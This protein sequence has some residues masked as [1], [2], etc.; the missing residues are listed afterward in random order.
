[1]FRFGWFRLRVIRGRHQSYRP[2]RL[3]QWLL[4][5]Y[6]RDAV[7]L[8]VVTSPFGVLLHPLHLPVAVLVRESHRQSGLW[9]RPLPNDPLRFVSAVDAESLKWC[10]PRRASYR[11]RTDGYYSS[12]AFLPVVRLSELGV[13]LDSRAVV[14]PYWMFPEP[15]EIDAAALRRFLSRYRQ[16]YVPVRAGSRLYLMDGVD[17]L[18]FTV[19]GTELLFL[20]WQREDLLAGL[21]SALDLLERLHEWR[22]HDPF[23]Y[24]LTASN[25]TDWQ[26][27]LD[28]LQLRYGLLA[29]D[30]NDPVLSAMRRG[31]DV[32][33]RS[34]S[35][36]CQHDRF[37]GWFEVLGVYKSMDGSTGRIRWYTARERVP[38]HGRYSLRKLL[39]VYHLYVSYA[40]ARGLPERELLCALPK[41]RLYVSPLSVDFRPL[42]TSFRL[43]GD[44]EPSLVPSPGEG[45]LCRMEIQHLFVDTGREDYRLV[46]NYRVGGELSVFRLGEQLQE[47]M[48]SS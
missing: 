26:Q 23:R 18:Q 4:D 32:L 19:D 40:G 13:P 16:E 3:V 28:S 15:D 34:G 7:Q 22:R 42:Y 30:A 48:H 20:S 21:A 37:A 44:T 47:A 17:V 25:G 43:D 14:V 41:S 8:H 29:T 11:A 9:V 6:F 1:M 35:P 33:E 46:L 45:R 39:R 24:P 31:E 36:G 38:L 12:R 10:L 2:S 5:R 27:I